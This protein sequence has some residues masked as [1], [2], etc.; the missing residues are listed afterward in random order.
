MLYGALID[1]SG[2]IKQYI[3]IPEN[4]KKFY[5]N[6]KWSPHA[7]KFQEVY[8]NTEEDRFD[9]KESQGI[10]EEL[11]DNILKLRNLKLPGTLTIVGY[12]SLEPDEDFVDIEFEFAGEY[13]VEFVPNN[14]K[15]LPYSTKVQM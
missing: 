10:T 2:A 11:L 14:P 7:L 15:Y 12:E 8:F 5:P 1:D 3:E 13:M 6:Y 4:M 9:S